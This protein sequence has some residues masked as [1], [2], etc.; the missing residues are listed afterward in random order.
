MTCEFDFSTT[1]VRLWATL[2]SLAMVVGVVAT[3]AVGR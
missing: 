2:G 3:V 1:I